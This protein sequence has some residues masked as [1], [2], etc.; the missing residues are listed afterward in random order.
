MASPT[1]NIKTEDV[2]S[3]ETVLGKRKRD[4]DGE[5][6][7]EDTLFIPDENHMSL[8]PYGTNL[9]RDDENDSGESDDD[10]EDVDDGEL[11]D[12][13]ANDGED[14][15]QIHTESSEPH[16]K[17]A[18][19]D[20]DISALAAV[21]TGIP[22]KV[23]EALQPHEGNGRH[24]NTHMA[25]ANAL[26]QIP[27]TKRPR[28][29]LVGSAG[30][31]KS[32]TFNNLVDVPNMAKSLSGGQSCT[33]VPSEFV[34]P[35]C[36]QTKP[37]AAVIFYYN[38]KNIRRLLA[39]WINDFEVA[40]FEDALEW[41]EDT[42]K[43]YIKRSVTALETLQV[44]FRDLEEFRTRAAAREYL[45]ANYHDPSTNA[46]HNMQLSCEKKLKAKRMRE[47]SYSDYCEAPTRGKLREM[48]DPFMTA[49]S[50]GNEPALWP[51]VR[52]VCIAIRGS[53]VLD[54][55]SII[56][57]PGISDTNETR[58]K[59]TRD[60]VKTCDYIWL[61]CPISRVIDGSTVVDMVY[62]YGRM[63]DEILIIC[64]HADTEVDSK[65]ATELKEEGQDVQPWYDLTKEHNSRNAKV[66]QLKKEIKQQSGRKKQTKQSLLDTQEKTA[67]LA[68]L[69]REL[70][71]IELR[72]YEFLVQ[73]RNEHVTQQL[74]ERMDGY[75]P[76][77]KTLQVCCISNSH[78]AAIKA[79]RTMRGLRLSPNGTGIP[80]LRAYAL[81]L[82]APALL[83][84][85]QEYLKTSLSVFVKNAQ[86]WVK[87]THVERR[88]EVLGLVKRPIKLL[89]ERIDTR[90]KAFEQGIQDYLVHAMHE[91][92][93]TTRAVAVKALE[94]KRKRHGATLMAFTRKNGNHRTTVCPK[95]SWNEQFM[96]GITDFVGEHWEALNNSKALITDDLRNV[97]VEDMSSILPLMTEEHPLTV[98]VLPMRR[99]AELVDA[100]VGA[101]DD[102]F[103]SNGYVY[104]Q[105]LRNI[106]MDAVHDSDKCYF[107]RTVQSTYDSCKLDSGAGV[108]KRSMD[109][110]E[111]HLSQEQN[112]SPFTAV[113]RALTAALTRND[114]KHMQLTKDSVK[115][116]VEAVF[117]S[118]YASFDRLVD[119]TVEHPRE[120]AA[121]E[122][123]QDLLVRL[124]VEYQEAIEKFGEIEARYAA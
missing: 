120:K 3:I 26:T 69:D 74:R 56:D 93:N 108:V 15:Q 9:D 63:F 37:Y 20:D 23:L 22:K 1:D 123:M 64:T 92:F 57:L 80:A 115:K 49:K 71:A 55:M 21:M 58:V 38:S 10:E 11:D 122:A 2:E 7:A 28:I 66:K 36:G 43:I 84:T 61:I 98:K 107:S 24:V 97:L 105:D 67:A 54:R 100:Q 42:R 113:E 89:Q 82:V 114:F 6:D 8:V 40:E 103:R 14:E 31:G 116:R 44:L 94:Q 90:L 117:E 104:A 13:S 112:D 110:I 27:P 76:A 4:D 35:F 73:V 83:R 39:E 60:F 18:I 102:I 72:R 119:K 45:T 81:K 79:G 29:A 68:T 124:E 41:D 19:Y 12:E 32:S 121:R 91:I 25:A 52:Q 65:L 48:V 70:K 118:L 111:T 106:Q 109:K 96:Q 47:G 87:T 77:G 53:R 16:P 88:A 34:A 85:F 101:I 46:L 51:L 62:R 59:T 99:L 17:C 50:N 86:L 33:C 30:S 78:Y 75:L 95:E 5:E